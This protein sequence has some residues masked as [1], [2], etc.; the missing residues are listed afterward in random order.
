MTADPLAEM[1]CRA[2]DTMNHHD[3]DIPPVECDNY[4]PPL[5]CLTAPSTETGR[6]D[7]C[8]TRV[9]PPGVGDTE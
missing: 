9:T 1:L 3:H 4:A 5:T 8:R 7:K 2:D 6:C